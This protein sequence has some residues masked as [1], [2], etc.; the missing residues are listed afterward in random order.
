[1]CEEPTGIGKN[2]EYNSTVKNVSIATLS[3]STILDEWVRDDRDGRQKEV[4]TG[5]IECPTTRCSEILVSREQYLQIIDSQSPWTLSKINE[6]RLSLF[7]RKVLGCIFGA[8][9]EN[10]IWR[11]RYKYEL[12]E[13]F[14]EPNVVTY[15]KI[16]RLEWAGHLVRLNNDRTLKRMFNTKPDGVRGV[17][18]P[19]L[20]WEDGVDQDMRILGVTN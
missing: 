6:W 10:G 16:K 8:K 11:K 14:N 20:R 7:E 1:V 3:S 5:I 13:T 18:R 12:Y 4:G 19:K 17:G 2:R 15:I 9:Q